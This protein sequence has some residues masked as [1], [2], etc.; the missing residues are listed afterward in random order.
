[1][2]PI[3]RL[4]ILLLLCAIS[5]RA[6]YYSLTDGFSPKRI[7]ATI[8]FPENL[9]VPT[10]T[11]KSL[12]QLREITAKPFTYLAK[13]SQAY[14]FVS[15]DGRFVLKLFKY[16]HMNPAEWML[17]IPVPERMI[18]YRNSLVA[19]RRHR[20]DL[21]LNSYKIAA[22]ILPEESGLLYA[23][24]LPSNAFS[25]PAQI[26]DAIG[27]TYT[28]D[29]AQHGFAIQQKADLIRPSFSKW[30]QN[31]EI[32]QAKAALDSIIGVL[33][34]RSEKGIQDSDPDLNKNAG[35]IGT[36]AVFIDIG[37][38]H[39]NPKVASRDEMKRDII[40]LFGRFRPWL[41]QQSPELG[42]YL[43]KRLEAPWECQW[44]EE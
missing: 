1:M 38:F 13:G 32:D 14:A 29:L 36:K 9:N 33:V 19:R 10:P 12:T 21:A 25:L 5:T 24:I 16:H 8:V 43:D 31:K 35:L 28:I 18:S 41:I 26:K 23:Q 20:I 37:S 6:V 40:K 7:E 44:S 30:L 17:D 2:P 15:A 22:T 34:H 27:R 11:P 3:K 42:V 4:A 39:K